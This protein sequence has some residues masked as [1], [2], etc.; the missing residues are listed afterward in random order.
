RTICLT[1]GLLEL[2]DDEIK[3]TLGHEFGHLAHK[4][5]DRILV[6]SIG[7]LFVT[8][9]CMVIQGFILLFQIAFTI[10]DA[11]S[12]DNIGEA[13]LK[14]AYYAFIKTV[15]FFIINLIMRAWTGI[16]CLLCMKTS[17]DCEYLADEFSVRMG[18]GTYLCAVLDKAGDVRLKGLFANLSK[19]HPDSEDR[20]DRIID[21]MEGAE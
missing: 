10:F 18:Y 5:T 19:S 13:I 16:G 9:I 17:R 11:A 21:L 12:S 15:M 1:E 6:I 14:G 4:D 7:N 20:I 3:A 2:S 8:G